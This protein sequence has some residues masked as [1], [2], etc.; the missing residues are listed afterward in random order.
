MSFPVLQVPLRYFERYFCGASTIFC[1]QKIGF[2]QKYLP[3]FLAGLGRTRFLKARKN[4]FLK[5]AALRLMIT[6]G[7][8]I[9]TVFTSQSI[10]LER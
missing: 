8:C 5:A 1:K 9:T 4:K 10:Q 2:P 3:K 7:K 6:L